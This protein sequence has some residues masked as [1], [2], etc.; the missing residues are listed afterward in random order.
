[1][2]IRQYI[3]ARY[4]PKF[5]DVNGGEWDNTYAYEALE[6]VKYGNDYYTAKKPV[7]TGAAITD[8]EYWVLTGNYNGAISN[9]QDQIDVLNSDI[10]A[11]ASEINNE[12]TFKN[13]IMLGDSWALGHSATHGWPYYLK[14]I[15]PDRNGAIYE[16]YYNGAGF[17]KEGPAGTTGHS[18]YHL[19]TEKAAAM[20]ADEKNSIDHILV[21]GGVNDSGMTGIT[22]KIYD[23]AD[24]A[25]AQFPNALIVIGIISQTIGGSITRFDYVRDYM[26]ADGYMKKVRVFDEH[27][28]VPF[29]NY[30]NDTH[31]TNAG[32]E[33][34]AHAIL[35]ELLGYKYGIGSGSKI[36]TFNNSDLNV[37]TT[38]SFYQAG[39]DI[40]VGI[41]TVNYNGSYTQS[42]ILHNVTFTNTTDVFPFNAN[43]KYPWYVK[44]AYGGNIAVVPCEYSFSNDSLI[45]AWFANENRTY[46]NI[47]LSANIIN[48]GSNR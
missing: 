3:G 31:C 36:L 43:V 6:I 20:T 15:L 42:G 38:L 25:I 28:C 18:F 4:V 27:N 41:G 17:V 29:Y 23:F 40:Q 16:N 35:N 34:C 10:Q 48:I 24:Y 32:Y 1:M 8:R 5:S 33:N 26:A 37:N 12:K 13:I 47:Y 2:S 9:L 21:M 44:L 45:V 11:V 39:N 30:A 19:L 22:Q 46:T 7:P 14:S